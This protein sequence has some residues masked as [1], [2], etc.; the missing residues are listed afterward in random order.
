MEIKLKVTICICYSPCNKARILGDLSFS[1][2]MSNYFG[3]YIFKRE[4]AEKSN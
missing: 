3:E 1:S 4:R 2:F